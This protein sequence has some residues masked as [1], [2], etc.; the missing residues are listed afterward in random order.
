MKVH[1]NKVHSLKGIAD[2]E[3]FQSIRMQSW[4][5]EGMERYSVLDEG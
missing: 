1:G 4:F 5:G 3:L 2:S